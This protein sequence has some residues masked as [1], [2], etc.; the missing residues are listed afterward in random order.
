M[1]EA[2]SFLGALL[3]VDFGLIGCIFGS[4]HHESGYEGWIKRNGNVCCIVRIMK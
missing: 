3:F 1:C 4:N 2:C